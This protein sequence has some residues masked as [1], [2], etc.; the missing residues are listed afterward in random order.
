MKKAFKNSV[1]LLFSIGLML[2]LADS[3]LI[4]NAS[5]HNN[6]DCEAV[7]NDI[8]NQFDNSHSISIE[9]DFFTTKTMVGEIDFQDYTI[10][11]SFLNESFHISFTNSIWQPPKLV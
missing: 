10:L 11:L 6:P 4:A 1:V 3:I 2:I 9:D 7:C 8:S 5:S